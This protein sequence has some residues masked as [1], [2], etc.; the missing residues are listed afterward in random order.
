MTLA[1]SALQFSGK[2]PDILLIE[3]DQNLVLD[4]GDQR[5]TNHDK[6]LLSQT[7]SDRLSQLRVNYNGQEILADWRDN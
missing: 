7:S 2:F 5:R 6:I 1:D 4:V 3:G